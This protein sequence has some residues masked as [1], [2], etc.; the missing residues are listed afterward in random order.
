MVQ[1]TL[2]SVSFRNNNLVSLYVVELSLLSMILVHIKRYILIVH[3][4]IKSEDIQQWLDKQW[5]R[6]AFIRDKNNR[7]G[8]EELAIIKDIESRKAA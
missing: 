8:S 4:D 3:L 5:P 7:Q 2:V 1:T 6:G